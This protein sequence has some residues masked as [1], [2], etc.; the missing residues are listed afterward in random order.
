MQVKLIRSLL[1]S[2]KKEQEE[3]RIQMK[4]MKLHIFMRPLLKLRN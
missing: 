2:K 4:V 1:G 3:G